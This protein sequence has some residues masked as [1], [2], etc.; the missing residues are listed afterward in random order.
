MML[1]MGADFRIHLAQQAF[2]AI[3]GRGTFQRSGGLQQFMGEVDGSH[4]RNA[5]QPDDIG[6]THLAHLLVEIARG[7][8]QVVTLT[9]GAGHPILLVEQVYDDGTRVIFFRNGARKEITPDGASI[10]HFANGDT[11]RTHTDG[12]IVYFYSDA[13]T[14]HTTYPDGSEYFEFPNGQTERHYADGRKEIC[15]PDKTVMVVTEDDDA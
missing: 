14:T 4:D 8:Q 6:I 3:T 10:V 1:L 13:E 5:F 7:T 11:K 15:F 2:E 12:R 9:G